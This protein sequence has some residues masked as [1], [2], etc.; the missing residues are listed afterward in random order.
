MTTTIANSFTVNGGVFYAQDGYQNLT[1]TV[2][3]GSSGLT[4]YT[5]WAGKDLSIAQL[6][7]SGPLVIDSAIAATR[8]TVAGGIVTSAAAGYTGTVTINAAGVASLAGTS[9][10]GLGGEL[11][12][13]TSGGLADATVVMNGTRGT[14]GINFNVANPVFGALGGAGNI[15]LTTT[16]GALAGTLTVGGDNATTTYTGILSGTGALAKVGSGLMA[17]AAVNTYTNGT[18]VSGGT[19]LI[20]PGGAVNSTTSWVGTG[21][22]TINAGATLDAYTNSFGYTA[23]SLPSVVINGGVLN[24]IA[25]TVGPDSHIGEVTMTGGTVSGS[26]FDPHLGITTLGSTA[27]ALISVATLRLEANNTFNVSAGTT[28]GAD[29]VVTSAI[30]QDGGPYG[31]TKAGGGL[32]AGYRREHLQRRHDDQRRDLAVGQRCG[33]LGGQHGRPDR[34]GWRRLDLNGYGAS[35]GASMAR[36]RL[37]T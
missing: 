21:T 5:Q 3:I 22:V 32:D 26:Q 33:D 15:A 17:L 20:N 23:G 13:A 11:E 12:L 6:A 27:E 18:T 31:I 16:A 14:S 35:I 25:G 34:R 28:G 4:A 29:L 37:T 9:A 2:T 8:Q 24:S 7:G 19:L 30:T 36:E 1:G 10:T